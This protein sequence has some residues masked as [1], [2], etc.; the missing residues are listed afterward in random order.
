M[1]FFSNY[2][3]IFYSINFFLIFLYLFPGSIVGWVVYRDISIQ[4][5]ITPNFIISS[6]HFYALLDKPERL[7]FVN[8]N[9][10]TFMM[11]VK[12]M[13]EYLRI[14]IHFLNRLIEIVK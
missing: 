6:S 10:F 9:Q 13:F 2:K 11:K 4:P 8:R 12:I 14:E 1:N 3:I 7:F 5:Q